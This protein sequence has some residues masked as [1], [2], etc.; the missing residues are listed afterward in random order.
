MRLIG[1][2]I[3]SAI[4]A[5]I[6]FMMSL[7]IFAILYISLG[8]PALQIITTFQELFNLGDLANNTLEIFK[9]TFLLSGLIV[10]FGLIMWL[11]INCRK[12]EVVT[13]EA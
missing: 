9:Y 11:Y 7:F 6:V 12:R 4:Y 1:F 5:V 13:Y 2:P 8:W 10:V 3:R